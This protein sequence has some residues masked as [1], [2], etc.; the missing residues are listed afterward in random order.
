MGSEFLWAASFCGQG[1]FVGSEV[2]R[3]ELDF[4]WKNE[5]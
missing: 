1:V 2:L 3:G 5:M 4:M